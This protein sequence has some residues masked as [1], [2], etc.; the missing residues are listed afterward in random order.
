MCIRDSV[1]RVLLPRMKADDVAATAKAAKD[2]AALAGAAR[3]LFGERKWS[4]LPKEAL[5]EV[6][7]TVALAALCHPKLLN[8]RQ[9]MEALKEIGSPAALE[10]LRKVFD[11]KIEIR[12]LNKED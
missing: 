9:T 3:W 11:G 2:T 1:I 6:V 10:L 5:D 8:R 4:D 12:K 7:K